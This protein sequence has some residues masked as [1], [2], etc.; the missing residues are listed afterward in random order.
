MLVLTSDAKY[1]EALADFQKA[2]WV[3]KG[4]QGGFCQVGIWKYSRHPNYFGEILQWWAAWGFSF[5]S[6]SGW[7]SAQ[8]WLGILSPLVTMQI[9]MFTSGT[10]VCNANGKNLKRYY[11]KCPEQY[12]EYRNSTSILIPMIGYKYVPMILKRTIFFDLKRYEYQP[13]DGAEP[14]VEEKIENA[15]PTN[16]KST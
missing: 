2:R 12:A 9:L 16:V 1:V 6:G 3:K 15:S 11:D 13:E 14:P 7:D 8:W 4:R 10:G 5:G